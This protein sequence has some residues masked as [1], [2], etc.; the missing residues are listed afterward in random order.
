M[1]RTMLMLMLLLLA[2]PVSAQDA[3]E[4][5]RLY[6]LYCAACHG[7]GADGRGPMRPV[8]IVPPADLTRLD[9]GDGAGFPL[10]RV[11]RRI[12]GRDPLVAHGSEMPVY[13]D[14]FEG[15]PAQIAVPGA[16]RVE[17]SIPVA[18]LVAYLLRLQQP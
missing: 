7:A 8:L 10:E 2:M 1:R 18:N 6:E 14:F 13:G 16:A 3:R 17:T 4:G 12:D 9:K 5:R 11:I 15:R